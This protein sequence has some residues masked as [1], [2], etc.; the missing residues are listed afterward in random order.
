MQFSSFSHM[1][2]RPMGTVILRDQ[3]GS[4]LCGPAHERFFSRDRAEAS[5][6]DYYQDRVSDEMDRLWHEKRRVFSIIGVDPP[7]PYEV[8]DR[9]GTRVMPT[10]TFFTG[11]TYLCPDC[12]LVR[13]RA[14][15][16]SRVNG[17]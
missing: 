1:F 16:N 11:T 14:K 13:E 2:D 5:I 7:D 8:C 17:E 9:C 12:A 4:Y 10:K 3:E 6:L 15:L